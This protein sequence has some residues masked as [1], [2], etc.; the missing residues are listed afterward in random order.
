MSVVENISSFVSNT[1][2]SK[3]VDD[4]TSVSTGGILEEGQIQALYPP[5]LGW[6][7][8]KLKP[9]ELEY[10]WR[11][12]KNRKRDA[13]QHLAANINSS[14]YLDDKNDWFYI[15]VLRGLMH[16]YAES[17]SNLGDRLPV[18]HRHPYCLNEWWVNYQKQG[19]FHPIHN[20]SGIYSFVL[21][22]KIPTSYKDQIKHPLSMNSNTKVMSTFQFHYSNMLGQMEPYRYCLSPEDEG[23]MLFFPSA[24]KHEVY[25]FFNCDEDRI[26]VAGNVNVNTSKIL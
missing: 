15:N 4:G 2:R 1:L 3:T 14:Y 17:F 5:N 18:I 11:C 22:M 26:S 23:V 6:L 13:S 25:P 10:V 21:W 9:T 12:I 24:L 8:Y 20:H 7:Q 19:E 16:R